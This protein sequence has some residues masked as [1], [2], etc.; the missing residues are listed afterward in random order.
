MAALSSREATQQ[1][2][3]V[4]GES[5]GDTMLMRG[6]SNKDRHNSER[7]KKKN[8]ARNYTEQNWVW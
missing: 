4:A 1:V 8:I 5:F 2:W 3:L 6:A 7:K